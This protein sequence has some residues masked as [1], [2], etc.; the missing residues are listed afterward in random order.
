MAQKI[1]PTSL[2]LGITQLWSF[3]IQSYGKT[4]KSYFLS[5][6]RYILFFFFLKKIFNLIG[7]VMSYQQWQI[8]KKNIISLKIYYIEPLITL[9][10]NFAQ[11]HLKIQNTLKKILLKK[12]KISYYLVDFPFMSRDLL[13]SYSKYFIS[14]KKITKKVLWNLFKFMESHLNS[15]KLVYTPRGIKVLKLKGFKIRIAGRIDDS[16]NQMAKSLNLSKGDSCL[17]SVEDYIVYSASTLYSKSGT[18]GLKIWLFYEL[19]Y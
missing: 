8:K 4:S 6:H 1:N 5:F 2:R 10:N 15:L 16:K 13:Y 12:V 7:L 18:C 9:N 11:F 17:T 14:E 3:N 19:I